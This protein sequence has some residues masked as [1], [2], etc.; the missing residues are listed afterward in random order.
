MKLKPSEIALRAL[1]IT[2]AT[3]AAC[4]MQCFFVTL[5]IVRAVSSLREAPLHARHHQR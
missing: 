1:A 2:G 4:A 5:D 3:A